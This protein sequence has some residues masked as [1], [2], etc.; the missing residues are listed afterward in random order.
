MAVMVVL[1]AVSALAAASPAPRSVTSGVQLE[2]VSADTAGLLPW[3]VD[4][5]GRDF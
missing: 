3:P 4:R 1:A 5:S 2:G